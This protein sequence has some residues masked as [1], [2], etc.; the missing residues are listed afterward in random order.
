MGI[1]DQIEDIR[2]FLKIHEGL[3]TTVF[4]GY[5]ADSGRPVLVKILSD[6]GSLDQQT[7]DRFH[8]EA[9][10]MSD[11]T[12]PN[13]VRVEAHGS[14][15]N[16]FYYAAEFIEGMPLDTLLE[17]GP[18]PAEIAAGILLQITRGLHAAH[19]QGILHQDIKPANVILS[20]EGVVKITDFGFANT[21]T[22]NDDYAL[23]GTL[24]YIAPELLH[25][26]PS[27]RSDLF[28]LGCLFVEALT[29]ERLFPAQIPRAYFQQVEQIATDPIIASITNL[30]DA[31]AQLAAGLLKTDPNERISS[32]EQ[33]LNLLEPYPYG[34]EQDI[35]RYMENPDGY[36]RKG[37]QEA[38]N[39]LLPSH[40][41]VTAIK[42]TPQKP[43]PQSS[44]GR[45]VLIVSALLLVALAGY[46]GLTNSTALPGDTPSE[47]QQPAIIQSDT[48]PPVSLDTTTT[49]TMGEIT[50]PLNTENQSDSSLP[51]TTPPQDIATVTVP[52][53][54]P[55]DSL[56][57]LAEEV[58]PAQGTTY[59]LCIPFCEVTL[60]DGST[61]ATPPIATVTRP[62]GTY[63][64]RLRNPSFPTIETTLE[65][66]PGQQDTTERSLWDYVARLNLTV[67]PWAYVW[68]NGDSLGSTPLQTPIILQAGP[69]Q[70]DLRHP[71]LAEQ[72]LTIEASPGEQ[73]S[74]AI[75]LNQSDP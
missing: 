73:I 37:L 2:L 21:P 24:G 18:M 55:P 41:E 52:L 66:T 43:Q 45:S 3:H 71:S 50:P 34:A 51:E 64:M 20:G 26:P 33:V 46:L 72:S 53:A 44:R 8:F 58:A 11:L 62:P 23:C 6:T 68:V 16:G 19:A 67:I 59:L 35:A 12:H 14:I 17:Q 36:S 38:F 54:N 39:A 65:I 48:P 27:T 10:V 56:P 28:S 61:F 74:R 31:L 40:Q 60:D 70:I 29:A 1:P 5:R 4:K 32:T 42:E 30:P 63:A 9:R 75:N 57:S 47:S 69:N 49:T 15:D 13:I 22:H 7:I 25:D